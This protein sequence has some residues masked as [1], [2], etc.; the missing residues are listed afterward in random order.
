M[1]TNPPSPNDPKK[2]AAPGTP[3]AGAKPPPPAAPGQKPAVPPQANGN[4]PASPGQPQQQVQALQHFSPR[5]NAVHV[6]G[7]GADRRAIGVM[8]LRIN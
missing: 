8:L 2:P 6:V 1:S 4:K 7:Y 5:S 3:A